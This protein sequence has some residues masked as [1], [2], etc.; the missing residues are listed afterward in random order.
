[1]GETQIRCR[2]CRA[3]VGTTLHTHSTYDVRGYRLFTGDRVLATI[4]A[5]DDDGAAT[6]DYL[7]LVDADTLWLC[8]VCIHDHEILSR[9]YPGD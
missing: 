8:P 1:V 6:K 7:R 2:G 3:E 5:R 9:L 4:Q